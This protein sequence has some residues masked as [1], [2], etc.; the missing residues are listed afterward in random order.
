MLHRDRFGNHDRL[1]SR[2]L[3][4]KKGAIANYLFLSL[5]I[6]HLSLV[7]SPESTVKGQR[8]L[9]PAPCFFFLICRSLRL[10]MTQYGSDKQIF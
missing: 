8:F 10:P 1:D 9:P 3:L 7:K 6:G 4:A 5:V 2:S